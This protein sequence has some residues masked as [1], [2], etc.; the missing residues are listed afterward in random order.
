[1]IDRRG[2]F[3]GALTL[4]TTA[5]ARPSQ[6]ETIAG[7]AAAD[8]SPMRNVVLTDREGISRAQGL[9]RF[10]PADADVVVVEAFDYNCGYCRNAGREL[11]ELARADDGLALVLFHLPILGPGSVEAAQLHAAVVRRH[12][13]DGARAL[14]AAL[15]QARGKVDGAKAQALAS[16]LGLEVGEEEIAAARQEVAG[17]R[18]LAGRLGLLYTPTFV[19]GD[20]A[21]I[22]WPGRPT[23]E[24]FAAMQR[25]CGR[26]SCG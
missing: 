22:G 7:L 16:S 20:V 3:A 12:G 5:I 2:F 26:I 14:H 1:M 6:A 19:I 10:G 18:A 11:D 9:T 24:R 15:L 23:L 25:R 8:G 4:A 17:Q 13:I 21:F